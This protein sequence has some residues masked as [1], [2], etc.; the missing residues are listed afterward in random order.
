MRKVVSVVGAGNV[1]E[2]VASLIAIKGFADVRLFD[3]PRKEGDKVFEPV[4]GKALDMKQMLSAMDIDTR[5]D[6]FTVT[7]EGDGYEPIARSDIVIITAGFPRRPGMS[8]EDLLEANIKI[9][10][11]IIT[12]V[13]QYSP[14]AILLVVTNPVDIMTYTAVKLS[15]FPANRVIGMAGVLDSARFKTFI[16]QELRVS[17]RDIHAYVIGGHGDEMV[18]LISM[19]NVGGIPL[20]DLLPREKLQEIIHRTRFGGGEI[21]ELMGTSAYYAPAAAV[22]DMVEALVTNSRRILPCSVY[23]DGEAGEYYGVKGFCVGVPVKLGSGGVEDIIKVPMI[24]EERE[25]WKRSVE[26]VK[27]SVE[28]AEVMLS[29]KSPSA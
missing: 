9:L 17:P 3:I 22:T 10:S 27:K 18:P 19:S 14:D 20:K 29:E 11:T 28:L 4:K 13:R 5:I 25:M 2:H 21:V 6:G 1:G 23:L 8:R 12:R 26:S 15:G 16:A 24:D 7:P